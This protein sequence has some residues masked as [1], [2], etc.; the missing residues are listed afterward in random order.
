MA[1]KKIDV[2][3]FQRKTRGYGNFSLEFIFNDV[4]ERLKDRVCFTVRYVPEFSNGFYKR[5]INAIYTYKQRGQINHITGDIHYINLLLKRKTTIL[6]V[7]DCGFMIEKSFIKRKLFEYFWLK[8]PERKSQ[9]ITAI[10]EATKRDIIKYTGCSPDKI[11]VIPVAVPDIFIPAIKTFDAT[12][13]VLLQIGTA[14]NKNLERLIYAIEPIPCQLVIVGKLSEHQ[15]QLLNDCNI[16]YKNL[17]NISLEEMYAQ[18]VK[19]DIVA[20]V[21]TFE[22][23]GMPIIEANCVERP[24]ITGNNSSMPEVGGNA[25][26]YVNPYSVEEIRTGIQKVIVDREYRNSLIENGKVNRRRYS[27]EQIANQYYELYRMVRG[28]EEKN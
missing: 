26:C 17:F 18:Y 27:G 14:A 5:L 3:H 6:T 12:C 10:S 1:K 22:G 7:L 28:E 23:F 8:F 4:R 24:V 11:F 19:C 9:Y 15:V 13:P 20:F 25:A 21:S 2:T 16:K